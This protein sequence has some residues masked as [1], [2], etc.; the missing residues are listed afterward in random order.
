MSIGGVRAVQFLSGGWIEKNLPAGKDRVSNTYVFPSDIGPT[1]L[2]MAGGNKNFLLKELSG[3][4]YGNSM[5]EYIKKS[6]N[7]TKLKTTHQM[8]RKV[9][10]SPQLFFDVAVDKTTKHIYMGKVPQWTPR[11]WEPIW[12]K[13]GDLVMDSAY[14]SVQPCRP[15]GVASDCCLF[16]IEEDWQENNPLPADCNALS[17]AGKQLF[18]IENGCPK[19]FNGKNL[20]PICIEPGGINKGVLPQKLSL[21]SQYGASGPFTNSRGVPIDDF[22]MKCACLSIDPSI[23][24]SEADFFT[25]PIFSPAECVKREDFGSILQ[26]V[27]C[28]GTFSFDSP[29]EHWLPE[30][31]AQNFNVS[32]YQSIITEEVEQR[33]AF[34]LP[35][36][37]DILQ[38][39]VSRENFS[40]WPNMGKFPFVI[41]GLDSC[42][43][44]GITPVPWPVQA[45][46][47]YMLGI[48]DPTTPRRSDYATGLCAMNAIDTYFCPSHENPLLQPIKQWYFGGSSGSNNGASA[49]QPTGLVG[50][51]RHVFNMPSATRY[52]TPYGTFANGDTWR[53]MS[54]L[55][56]VQKCPIQAQGTAFIG[57]GPNGLTV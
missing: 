36:L 38:K 52:T 33:I 14:Y 11:L 5:W 13:N 20:N 50:M 45:M 2:E 16:N 15:N 19:D 4:T 24:K 28:D 23:L 27:A 40:A 7:L 31:G 55:Q 35:A 17:L 46:T 37:V 43:E 49:A 18:V 30:Y 51:I 3:P 29:I 34:D 53:S 21:W 1:L 6:V 12:P 54:L 25:L 8:V 32:D 44:K 48:R 41:D 39:Y 22:S 56:C 10:Y 26:G 9:S 47:P 57:D 42:P